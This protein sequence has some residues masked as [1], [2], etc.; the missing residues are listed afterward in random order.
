[1]MRCTFVLYTNKKSHMSFRMAAKSVT[2][3]DLERCNGRYCV[4]L[5]LNS[6]G[7]AEGRPVYDL[8]QNVVQRI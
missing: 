3:N 2:L 5:L 8:Q 4:F 6:V 1:M 7:L